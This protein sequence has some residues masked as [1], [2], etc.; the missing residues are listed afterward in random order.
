MR[1]KMK[2]C[3]AQNICIHLQRRSDHEASYRLT[4]SHDSNFWVTGKETETENNE[5]LL[6]LLLTNT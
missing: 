2:N 6:C 1:H 4:C 3:I 5:G